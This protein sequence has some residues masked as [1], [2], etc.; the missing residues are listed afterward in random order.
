MAIKELNDSTIS[1]FNDYLVRRLT[2]RNSYQRKIAG[3]DKDIIKQLGDILLFILAKEGIKLKPNEL[4]VYAGEEGFEIGSKI[5][6]RSRKL[7][8][9]MTV[10]WNGDVQIVDRDHDYLGVIDTITP[11][12]HKLFTHEYLKIK[13]N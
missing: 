5:N 13:F 10:K 6:P 2:K 12:L 11:Y 9:V 3:I 1:D 7:R 8:H 4:G